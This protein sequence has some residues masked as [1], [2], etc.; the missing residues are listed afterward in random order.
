MKQK[1]LLNIFLLTVVCQLTAEKSLSFPFYIIP[2]S[3]LMERQAFLVNKNKTQSNLKSF[4][5]FTVSPVLIST[6]QTL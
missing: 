2:K 6:D 5:T 4:I 1:M 3:K